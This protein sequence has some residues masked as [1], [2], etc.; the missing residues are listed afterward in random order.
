MNTV[1][2]MIKKVWNNSKGVFEKIKIVPKIILEEHP[3]GD[4]KI[5]SIE[6]ISPNPLNDDLYPKSEIEQSAKILAFG[7]DGTGTEDQC[8]K[9]RLN[10]G[11]IPNHEPIKICPITGIIWSGHTRYYAALLVGGKYVYVVYADEVYADYIN[12]RVMQRIL[13]TYNLFKRPEFSFK[14]QV[15]KTQLEMKLIE[16]EHNLRS[17]VLILA[18]NSKYFDKYYKKGMSFLQSAFLNKEAGNLKYI[19][20]IIKIIQSGNCENIVKDIDEGKLALTEAIKNLNNIKKKSYVVNSKRFNFLKHFDDNKINFL[21]KFKNYFSQARHN[22]FNNILVETETLGNINIVTDKKMGNENPKK[23]GVLSDIKMSI[24]AIVYNEL[25]LKTLTAGTATNSADIQFPDLTK[26][27]KKLNNDY[28]AEEIEVKAAVEKT[29]N[30]T[31]YGGPDMKKHIKEYIIGV[32]NENHTEVCMFLTTINGPLVV[33]PST[34]QN[35]TMDLKTILKYHK[36]DMR[37][38]YGSVDNDNQLVYEKI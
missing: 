27:A 7:Q 5:V 11:N 8:M 30:A 28:S 4:K 33:K 9:K 32:Y 23:T 10:E 1:N 15:F 20:N 35:T 18:G 29:G 24:G 17:D 6:K 26:L 19:K 3:E 25:G 22:Y 16:R 14:Q 37:F 34:K 21:R 31:F 13:Q 2:Q 38:I 36:D 12:K